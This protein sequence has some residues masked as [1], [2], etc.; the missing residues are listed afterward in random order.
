MIILPVGVYCL[1]MVVH[2]V[3][4]HVFQYLRDTLGDF[5]R[6][7]LDSRE[8]LEVDPMKLPNSNLLQKHQEALA[9]YCEMAWFKIINS[10]SHLPR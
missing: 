9:T 1:A 5:I 6:T 7:V 10:H 2:N 3:P 8:E 4:V